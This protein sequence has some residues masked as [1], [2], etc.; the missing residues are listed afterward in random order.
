MSLQRIYDVTPVLARNLMVS[1][2]GYQ[3]IK[4]GAR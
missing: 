2:S 1:A 3:C 4:T